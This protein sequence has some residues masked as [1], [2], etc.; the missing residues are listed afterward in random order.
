VALC[1]PLAMPRSTLCFF[2]FF[3]FFFCGECLFFH[4][5]LLQARLLNVKG[6]LAATSRSP[7]QR[8][9]PARAAQGHTT[10]HGTMLQGRGERHRAPPVPVKKQKGASASRHTATGAQWGC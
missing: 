7:S 10:G 2:F 1:G 3:F 9:P 5:L 4:V 6:A 8:S